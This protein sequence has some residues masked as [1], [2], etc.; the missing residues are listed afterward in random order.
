MN[1]FIQKLKAAGAEFIEFV[2]I[3]EIPAEERRDFPYAVVV[4]MPISKEGIKSTFFGSPNGKAEFDAKETAAEQLALT[5]ERYIRE[6]GYR[7]Y[8]QTFDN[9]VKNDFFNQAKR[10]SK[11]PD[12]TI[13]RQAGM[14]WIGKNAVLVTKKYGSAISM[15]TVLTD[16][17]YI[18]RDSEG[19]GEKTACQKERK[20]IAA[21]QCGS[22][23]ACKD[24]CHLKII[25]TTEEWRPGMDRDDMLDPFPC[26]ECLQCVAVCPWT[27]KYGGY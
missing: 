24:I 9:N 22:C 13:A 6:K 2:D 27:R 12:K 8:A 5:A 18:F 7:A 21:Q 16:M 19:Q 23:S 15:C 17:P 4:G 10:R 1:E 14:G 26:D 25:R 3:H 11:L 20:P